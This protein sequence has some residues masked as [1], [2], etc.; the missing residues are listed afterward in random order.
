MDTAMRDE[1]LR[2]PTVDELCPELVADRK[3]L[4]RVVAEAA[5]PVIGRLKKAALAAVKE[6]DIYNEWK[7]PGRDR[8]GLYSHAMDTRIVGPGFFPKA[9]KDGLS[10]IELCAGISTSLEAL[11]KLGVRI[12]EYFYVD[13]DTQSRRVAEY[14]LH[15]L[16]AKFPDQFPVTAWKHA[17][18]LPQDIRKVTGTELEA[19]LAPNPTGQDDRQFLVVAGWPCQEYSPAGKANVGSRAALLDDVL[20]IVRWLQQRHQWHP[21]G[22][23]LENVAMQRN[24]RHEHIRHPVFAEL[25]SRI[26]RPVTFDGVQVG[27]RA[28][29]L[30]NYWTNLTDGH[31]ADEVFTKIHAYPEG[32][33][34]QI[35]GPGRVPT[36]V[37]EV[38]R[39]Q[40]EI[41][42]N[43][44]G[45]ARK[46]FPTI[47][48][49][50]LSR[51]FHPGKPGSL[52]DENTQS[53]DE[54]NP[55][56]REAALGY[57]VGGT[58]APGVLDSCRNRMLGQA[59][60]VR[61]IQALYLVA[62]LMSVRGVAAHDLNLHERAKYLHEQYK[63]SPQENV[64]FSDLP[65]IALPAVQPDQESNDIWVDQAALQVLKQGKWPDDPRESN[66]LRKRV[67]YY[68]WVDGH[69]YRTVKDKL[70]GRMALRVVP[71]P[72]YREH[73]ILKLHAELGHVG[74]KRTIDAVSQLYWWH[75]LTVDVRRCLSTCKL[76][77]RV[78]VAPGHETSEMQT[79]P[80][81]EYGMFCRWGLDYLGDQAPSAEGNRYALVAIDYYSKWIEVFPVQK[82]DAQTTVRTVLTSL[83]ARY[84]VPAEFVCDN[85]PPFQKDFE[86]F[87]K[88]KQ[89]YINFITPGMPRSNGLAER[90]VKT[91]KYALKKHAAEARNAKTWDTIGLASIL[92]GYRCTRQSATNLSPAQILFAQN[93]AVHPDAWITQRKRMNFINY[94]ASADEL[95]RRAEI[96]QKLNIQVVNNLKAAHARNA[97]R[98][99]QLRSGL[100][101]PKVNLFEVG[102]YVFLLYPED[103]V[104]GGALGIQVRDEILRVVKVNDNGTLLLENQAGKQLVRHMEQCAHCH[105][106]NIEGTVH[107]D[108]V[109]PSGK[110]PC[111]LCGDHRRANRLLMC[112]GC[113]LGYHT[114]CLTPPL[115]DIPEGIWICPTCQQ[116]G[117]TA[118]DVQQRRE[119]YIPVERSRPAIELPNPRRRALA[120]KMVAEWHGKVVKH[121][122]QSGE[123]IGR[124]VFTDVS[125]LKWFNIYWTDGTMTEHDSRIFARLE[126]IPEKRAPPDI[127]HPPE[128]VTVLAIT[129]DSTWPTW[130]VRTQEDV[131][132]RL[133]TVMPGRHLDQT[134]ALVH[135]WFQR[136]KPKHLQVQAPGLLMD[137]LFSV[138]NTAAFR[139]VLDPWAGNLMVSK[140][141]PSNGPMLLTNDVRGRLGVQSATEPLE[142]ALY[143][144]VWRVMGRLDAIIMAPPLLLAQVACR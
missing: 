128:A 66:R 88:E 127:M 138:V 124:I 82:A 61:A 34:S 73:M 102:D 129:S 26:G 14:R 8:P 115:I 125:S 12:N 31:R 36:P 22:Y 106:T 86:R 69:L 35:L 41:R 40:S 133:K 29:R 53:W 47:M 97:A 10:L 85:G 79:S 135:N 117:V 100:Y 141:W 121:T 91:I 137:M 103:K 55:E 30:R 64:T 60:D 142:P 7:L 123:R 54:P 68:R 28:H 50:P 104:P 2:D 76:C 81:S 144:K 32:P 45:E 116:F 15:E 70:T 24:F 25:L 136:R 27:S 74:E 96:A 143:A 109:L 6:G 139:L 112:D 126:V 16:S 67:P 17:F 51:A 57:D 75:G 19:T 58:A 4:M 37:K 18:D 33:L 111:T 46:V 134:I 65:T 62:N 44:Y 3:K 11:L 49:F 80:H 23:I 5:A 90:A 105:L 38:E 84:G 71:K 120:R 48:S 52:F 98:F 107:P 39:S 13:N 140:H 87:C 72:E 1:T 77:Q 63:Q 101:R 78:R 118:A 99:R 108:A 93:P 130:S 20:R 9:Q 131:K 132:S 83:I 21:P 43:K 94:E 113:N 114:F 42:V 92:L 110:Y 89:I 59:M 119:R 56:E 122:R 95:L